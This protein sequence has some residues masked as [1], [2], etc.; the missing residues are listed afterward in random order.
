MS[1]ATMWAL[2]ADEIVMGAHS[3]LGPIDPQLPTATGYQP[4]QAILDQFDRA[5][6]E[7]SADPSLLAPWAPIL[8]QYGPA[9]LQLCED[10]KQLAKRLVKQ[11][12]LDGMLAP[13]PGADR[14]DQDAAARKADDVAD[15]FAD[16]RQH[17]SHAVGIGRDEARGQGLNVTNLEADQALQDAVL[18]VHHSTMHTLNATGAV[19]IIENH[20]GRAFIKQNQVTQIQLPIPIG[21]PTAPPAAPPVAPG[22]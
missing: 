4:A 5:K 18:S 16:Y 10:A 2:S 13:P 17:Q 20:L 6:A 21:P 14:A 1:A 3:Q 9:L 19:K 11:W 8:Q 12:L 22:P 15:F 7:V